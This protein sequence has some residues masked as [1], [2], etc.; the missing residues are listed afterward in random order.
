MI[1]NCFHKYTE[2]FSMIFN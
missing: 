2:I 1:S